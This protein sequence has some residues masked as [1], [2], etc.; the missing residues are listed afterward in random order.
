VTFTELKPWLS[1]AHGAVFGF[2]ISGSRMVE[3]PRVTR[4]VL[5]RHPNGVVLLVAAV[6]ALALRSVTAPTTS[7]VTDLL[8]DLIISNFSL[9][10]GS[11]LASL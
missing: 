6:A 1:L 4:A 3:D 5:A 11:P 9:D 8:T 7:T 2:A 10:N